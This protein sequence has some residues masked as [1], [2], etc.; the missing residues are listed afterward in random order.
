M[1]LTPYDNES[2]VQRCYTDVLRV[3][4][5]L[6]IIYRSLAVAHHTSQLQIRYFKASPSFNLTRD[7]RYSISINSHVVNSIADGINHDHM[8]RKQLHQSWSWLVDLYC[9]WIG[10]RTFC[11]HGC[12][13]LQATDGKE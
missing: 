2:S 3:A 12:A 10:F 1:E 11:D 6:S 4:Q 8:C 5:I 9:L 13:E 7:W